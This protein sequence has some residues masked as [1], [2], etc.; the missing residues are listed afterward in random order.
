MTVLQQGIYPP[1]PTFFDENEGLDLATFRTHLLWLADYALAGILVMGSNGEA[2]HLTN[3][4]RIVMIRTARETIDTAQKIGK[5]SAWLLLAGTADFTTRGTIVRCRDAATAG[6]D[7]AVVLPP[8]GFP[9]QMTATALITHYLAVA[10]ASPIPITIYNMPANTGGIDL[11][12]EVILTVAK[13]PNVVGV[14]DSSGNVAKI[15]QIAAAAPEGFGVLAGSGHI[16]LSSLS[17]GGI[18]AIA[19]VANVIPDLTIEVMLLWQRH[20]AEGNSR[21][22]LRAREVQAAITPLNQAVTTQFGVAGLKAALQCTRGYGGQPRRPLMPVSDD[23]VAIIQTH[24][25]ITQKGRNEG[26]KR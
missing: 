24:F 1:V 15:G 14:K 8:S 13:H 17:V 25:D 3:E 4:E 22:L 2:I 20:I 21:D 23:T 16:L 7:L 18:G 12:P 9:S 19:A 11:S 10:E 26:E 5:A 6:A